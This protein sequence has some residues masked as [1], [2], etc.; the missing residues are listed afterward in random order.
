[1]PA[2]RDAPLQK[3]RWLV[4]SLPEKAGPAVPRP[5]L[6]ATPEL[7]PL[8]FAHGMR[9]EYATKTCRCPSEC[10]SHCRFA[11]N[12]ARG[13]WTVEYRNQR[14]AACRRAATILADA[15]R[16]LA[17]SLIHSAGSGVRA[18]S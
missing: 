8:L 5:V 14:K 17:L 18:R 2:P 7:H 9:R 1:M 10:R 11:S 13:P 6:A 12:R 16:W 3:T 15:R 4:A